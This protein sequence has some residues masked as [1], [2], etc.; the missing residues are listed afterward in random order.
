[1]QR[2]ANQFCQPMNI[3]IC[4]CAKKKEWCFRFKVYPQFTC[5][6]LKEEK[7]I[8]PVEGALLESN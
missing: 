4:C 6:P 3:N 1:M 5:A 2:T 7:F 8:V